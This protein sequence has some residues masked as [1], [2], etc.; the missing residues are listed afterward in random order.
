[1]LKP[2]VKQEE[3]LLKLVVLALVLLQLSLVVLDY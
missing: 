2:Q 1:V 3:P